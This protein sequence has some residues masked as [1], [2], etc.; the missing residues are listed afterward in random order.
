MRR[1]PMAHPGSPNLRSPTRFVLWVARGQF[2]LLALGAVYGVLWAGALA[3]TPARSPA[4]CATAR[5][6]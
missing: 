6:W 3:I 2:G 1:L 4:S 5:W